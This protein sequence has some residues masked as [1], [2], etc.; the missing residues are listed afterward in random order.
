MLSLRSFPIKEEE[1]ER[2]IPD[3]RGNIWMGSSRRLRLKGRG[4]KL[5]GGSH[6]V[7]LDESGF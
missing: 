7:S 6:E 3:T 2:C 1:K 5:R 4:Q